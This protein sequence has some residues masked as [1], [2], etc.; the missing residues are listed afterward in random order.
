MHLEGTCLFFVSRLLKLRVD[1]IEVKVRIAQED[2][3]YHLLRMI[4]SS[5]TGEWLRVDFWREYPDSITGETIQFCTLQDEEERMCSLEP[6]PTSSKMGNKRAAVW[7][8]QNPMR[9]NVPPTHAINCNA[10]S[11]AGLQGHGS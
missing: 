6:Y 4:A 8:G 1:E 7:H 2:G 10:R 9:R 3:S 5:M 11:A